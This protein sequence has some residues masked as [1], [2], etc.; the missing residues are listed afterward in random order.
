MLKPLPCVLLDVPAASLSG[1][2]LAV[3]A[4]GPASAEE[5]LGSASGCSDFG[6]GAGAGEMG[7][8][9]GAGICS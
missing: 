7:S 2:F 9:S 5:P 3:V 8:T 4:A 6:A 1:S